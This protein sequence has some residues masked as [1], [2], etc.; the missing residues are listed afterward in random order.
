MMAFF[1]YVL[2]LLEE[3]FDDLLNGEDVCFDV[4]AQVLPVSM[5][6]HN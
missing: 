4:I 6:S 2:Q 3:Y 1:V 5:C